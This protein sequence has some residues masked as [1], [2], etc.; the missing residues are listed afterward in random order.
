MNTAAST[1]GRYV[2][3]LLAANGTD[4]VFGIPRVHAL[5]LY[6][7]LA[8]SGLRHV[9]VRH[10]QGGGFAAADGYARDQA[11]SDP[12]AAFVISG[13]GVTNIPDANG[14]SVFRLGTDARRREH[15]GARIARQADG[16]FCTSFPT[17][18][19]SSHR[20]SIARTPRSAPRTFAITC[21]LR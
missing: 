6:R 20:C 10:E 19:R 16:E 7:G 5:E 21:G 11:E 12:A 14:A 3:E 15:S 18:A 1:L 8:D 4:T 9:L 17:S 2:A 13:P